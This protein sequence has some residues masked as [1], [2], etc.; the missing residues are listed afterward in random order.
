MFS[1][2][3]GKHSCLLIASFGVCKCKDY[4]FIQ[5]YLSKIHLKIYL[6]NKIFIEYTDAASRAGEYENDYWYLVL[7]KTSRNEPS[8]RLFGT[9][10]IAL[11]TGY[12]RQ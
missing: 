12:H 3:I 7:G 2:D 4:L 5:L 10:Q 6:F 1:S 9:S 8:R 11:Q